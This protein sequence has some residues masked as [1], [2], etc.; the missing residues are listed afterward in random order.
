MAQDSLRL[1]RKFFGNETT[2]VAESLAVLGL[3]YAQTGK[4]R[5]AERSV[6]EA[7]NIYRKSKRNE[8]PDIAQLL[9]RLARI[10]GDLGRYEQSESLAREALAI[11]QTKMRLGDHLRVLNALGVL[12]RALRGEHKLAEAQ[13][14]VMEHLAM[15][16][17]MFPNGGRRIA[18]LHANGGLRSERTRQIR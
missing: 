13:A 9:V 12:A 4:E 8:G 10:E 18:R 15:N 17:R 16:R 14:V 1:R 3:V 5:Q 11:I 7:V 6:M 2:E